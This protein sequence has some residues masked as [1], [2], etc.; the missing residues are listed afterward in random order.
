VETTDD[1]ESNLSLHLWALLRWFSVLTL[2]RATVSL[3]H[4]IENLWGQ[5][6][7][8][9]DQTL[10]FPVQLSSS[11]TQLYH[12]PVCPFRSPSRSVA[13]PCWCDPSDPSRKSHVQLAWHFGSALL[14]LPT[15]GVLI[16]STP[17]LQARWLSSTSS[18]LEN[19]HGGQ[20]TTSTKLHRSLVLL[21]W[22]L[23]ESGGSYIPSSPWHELGLFICFTGIL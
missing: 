11:A 16:A 18:N 23:W 9:L 7:P 14:S 3:R 21:A 19:S 17:E 1:K 2:L 8:S 10:L 13:C 4:R 22:L 12:F 5:H 15:M 6:L 20:V